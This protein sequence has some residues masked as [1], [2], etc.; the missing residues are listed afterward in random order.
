MTIHVAEQTIAVPLD[1]LTLSPLNVRKR[2]SKPSQDAE[3]KATILAKGLQ[4]NLVVIPTD[5][6]G[7]FA[8]VA[9]G[10]R[11]K[12]LQDLA[13]DGAIAADYAVRCIVVPM[14]EGA[15]HSL[16]ENAVRANM[17]PAEEVLAF[18]D[19]I[20]AQDWSFDAVAERYGVSLR[21]V[22]QRMKL[23]NVAPV[24]LDAWR[25]GALTQSQV[26]AFA[27]SDDPERQRSYFEDSSDWALK[28]DS[29]RKAMMDK[30]LAVGRDRFATFVGREDYE[31]AGGAV[32][33]DLFGDQ[34]YLQDAALVQE[35]AVKKLQTLSDEIVARECWAWGKCAVEFF[36]REF[37][38][39]GRIYGKAAEDPEGEALC[40][41]LAEAQGQYDARETAI[42]EACTDPETGEIDEQAFEGA[43]DGDAELERI[44][45]EIEAATEALQ[46]HRADA[47]LLYGPAEKALAGVALS[48]SHDGKL[49][50]KR[51]LV[52]PDQVP[53][54]R[55]L[56]DRARIR[57]RVIAERERQGRAAVGDDDDGDGDH[58]D[59]YGDAIHADNADEDGAVD[60][61]TVSAE[62]DQAA[63]DAEVEAEL[64]R[65]REAAAER[66]R[67]EAE[68]AAEM[69]GDLSA[70]LVG[71]LTVERTAALRATVAERPDLALRLVVYQCALRTRALPRDH[72]PVIGIE[73]RQT[74][75]GAHHDGPAG[76]AYAEAVTRLNTELPDD[77]GQLFEHVMV[78]NDEELFAILAVGVAGTLDAH[79]PGPQESARAKRRLADRFAQAADLDMSVWWQ[80]DEAFFAR[81][82]KGVMIEAL[83]EAAPMI[84]ELSTD[85]A[86]DLAL[87][88]L[89]RMPKAELVKTTAQALEGTGWL[90]K[91]LR[92]PGI[93][94]GQSAAGSR[95][96]LPVDGL[97]DDDPTDDAAKPADE[98]GEDAGLGVTTSDKDTVDD[99][100]QLHPAP[101]SELPPWLAAGDDAEQPAGTAAT[102]A[103]I[104]DAAS[105]VDRAGEG[106]EV[107]RNARPAKA[108]SSKGKTSNSGKVTA[109]AKPPTTGK[110][111]TA[112]VAKAAKRKPCLPNGA[113]SAI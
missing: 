94:N 10:R 13:T 79:I 89:A 61:A 9:G 30:A 27:L 70:A 75:L 62:D 101:I 76:K 103:G 19:L 77:P 12:A 24:I 47:A 66:Q 71:S 56:Q 14:E 88:D 37:E 34:I 51:G 25:D 60:A 95:V 82:S 86:R 22:N 41:R 80:A 4:Q 78:A 57:E 74:G 87:A 105:D 97:T 112:K 42:T 108:K 93:G 72:A 84:A 100:D 44:S 15:E 92:T 67:R 31:A 36:Y 104:D 73:I 64:V 109:G 46:Q 111:K 63:I 33:T 6:D 20:L 18:R 65:Q 23:A 68:H 81:V 107:A 43:C 17:H 99:A 32:V 98:I 7:R 3:L 55:E 40:A 59:G 49:E 102:A 2:P 83:R 54:L 29:I 53:K 52:H 26:E 110:N 38:R 39:H 85:Q 96:D 91:P 113:A 58:G 11:L 69:K 16:I 90:P 45:A 35:L 28:P 5:E 8:V 1:K 48:I 21:V 106:S 50:L